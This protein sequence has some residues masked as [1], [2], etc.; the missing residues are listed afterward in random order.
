M[1][2]ADHFRLGYRD[3]K[4]VLPNY[5]WRDNRLVSIRY[6][7]L[8]ETYS[9]TGKLLRYISE[10]GSSPWIPYG[11][12]AIPQGGGPVLFITEGE[13]K[14]ISVWQMGFPC[15]STHGLDYRDYW[16]DFIRSFDRVIY[17]RD[18]RDLGGIVAAN[19]IKRALKRVEIVR[20]PKPYKAVDDYFVADRQGCSA[21]INNIAKGE[22]YDNP[23]AS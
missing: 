15:I 7:F 4:I 11:M 13:F 12:W 19:K 18:T 8:H 14:A 9:K 22:Q 16:N 17:L 3:F 23:S 21:F 5:D 2:A 20:M 1:T 10:P 6:R